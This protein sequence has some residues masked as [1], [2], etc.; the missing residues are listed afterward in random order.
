MSSFVFF[1]SL[2]DESDFR[3]GVI[4]L[5][6]W[7]PAPGVG[8]RPCTTCLSARPPE[9]LRQARAPGP[10]P[11]RV[12]SPLPDA[13]CYREC[14]SPRPHDGTEGRV[15][16]AHHHWDRG[17][18]PTGATE[19]G[20][21]SRCIDLL[22]PNAFRGGGL[23]AGSI[24]RRS[25]ARGRN[26]AAIRV[27]RAA[28][29]RRP[30]VLATLHVVFLVDSMIKMR[31]RSPEGSRSDSPGARQNTHKPLFFNF[32]VVSR[33]NSRWGRPA[34]LQAAGRLCQDTIRPGTLCV[35]A[36]D[37]GRSRAGACGVRPRSGAPRASGRGS[38]G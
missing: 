18:A 34:L 5:S 21:K 3:T 27:A 9:N 38:G 16:A 33:R 14:G 25:S 10:G 19:V 20:S 6:R 31:A 32:L 15:A 36:Q 12:P 29:F 26:A 13:S 35:M 8:D 2:P 7:L 17:A 23:V 37:C 11:V 28:D 4:G 24:R 30:S 1:R 22:L